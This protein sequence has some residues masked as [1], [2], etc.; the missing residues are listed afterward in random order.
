ML[1]CCLTKN[2]EGQNITL[3]LQIID[4]NILKSRELRANILE[5]PGLGANTDLEKD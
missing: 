3:I 4:N 2:G 5:D 1:L